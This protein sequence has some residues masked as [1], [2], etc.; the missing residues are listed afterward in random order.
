MTRAILCISLL[1]FSTNSISDE[2]SWTDNEVKEI[3]AYYPELV[4]CKF[5]FDAGYIAL[6][7]TNAPLP[8]NYHKKVA[9]LATKRFL[10]E[11]KINNK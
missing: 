6:T 4:R 2:I 8:E 1:L 11:Q 9:D 5:S 10:C 3:L 7:I